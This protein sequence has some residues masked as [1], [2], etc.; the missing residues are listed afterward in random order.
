M[1]R[2]R[3]ILALVAAIAGMLAAGCGN[4]S[5]TKTA[6][7]TAAISDTTE[8]AESTSAIDNTTEAAVA[9]D[10]LSKNGI[11]VTPQGDIMVYLLQDGEIVNTPVSVSIET[12]KSMTPGY[13]DTTATFAITT[14]NGNVWILCTP[15]DR[16]TGTCLESGLISINENSASG[17]SDVCVLEVDGKEYYC[18]ISA[19]SYREDNMCYVT[20]TEHH[21]SNYDGTVFMFSYYDEAVYEIV[22]DID[23][24]VQ[25]TL[26]R[27]PQLIADSHFFTE[28]NR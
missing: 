3:L 20:V 27:Y 13:S 24:S 4:T 28:S 1:R 8:A 23:F 14:Q 7:S 15:F 26:D 12:Q 10:F 9:E 25:F 16:Y 6:E 17:S 5:V 22:H 19:S 11:K 2:K 18:S 21:P